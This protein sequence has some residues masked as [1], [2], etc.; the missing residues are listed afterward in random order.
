MVRE[1]YAYGSVIKALSSGLYPD[2]RHVI[3]EFIQNSFDALNKLKDDFGV[4]PVYKIEIYA[5][6]PSIVICDKG[7][8]MDEDDTQKFR[9]LGYSEKEIGKYVGFRVIG[10]DSGIAVAEKI[11]VT[12]SKYKIPKGYRVIIDAQK[13][14]EEIESKG[15]PPLDELLENN[16]SIGYF[17]E[18][19][20]SHYTVTELYNIRKDSQTL[21]EIDDLKDYISRNAPVPYSPSFEYKSEIEQRIKENYDD[22]S[23]VDITLNGKNIYKPFPDNYKRPEYELV[24]ATDEEDSPLV[25]ICWYCAHKQSSRFKDKENSGLVFRLNNFA[26]GDKYL[27]RKNLWS[28]TPERAFWFFGEVHILDDMLRPSS[29][30]SDFEDNDARNRLYKRCKRISQVLNKKAGKESDRSR[31]EEKIDFTEELVKSKKEK[32]I[33][34]EIPNQ[35]KPETEFQIRKSKEDLEKRLKRTKGKRD[36]SEEDEKLIKKAEKAIKKVNNT[37]ELL[38][39]EN[40]LKDIGKEVGFDN[41]TRLLYKIIID[42]LK[43]EFS[44]DQE[45]LENLVS[46]IN[47]EIKKA[48]K[49]N[50]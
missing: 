4:E 36:K 20:N 12:T 8:G 2:K 44:S 17:D 39:P 43:K 15:N 10:K 30:R 34:K 33:K 22:F 25:A 28:A 7:I 14:I 29:Y 41:K 3:R 23:F 46:R 48:F 6:K 11:I 35:L 37:L 47:D 5:Q 21:F 24:F 13:M 31:F 45:K 27:T 18:N 1:T 26:V 42:I 40:S 16:S 9:Y 19:P 49:E 32:I 50:S 38:E